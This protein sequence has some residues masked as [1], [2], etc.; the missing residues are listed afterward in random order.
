M[1]KQPAGC[2]YD[3]PNA[4]QII[5]CGC[6]G[7]MHRVNYFG[8]CRNDDERFADPEDFESRWYGGGHPSI[9]VYNDDY[10]D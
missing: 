10:C 3:N 2:N 5:E 9:E 6:C 7:G 1:N 4:I 8:D